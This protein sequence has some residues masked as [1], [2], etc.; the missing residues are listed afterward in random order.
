MYRTVGGVVARRG[1]EQVELQGG[2]VTRTGR[3]ELRSNAMMVCVEEVIGYM[4]E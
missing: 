4:Q 3:G 2:T 1:G